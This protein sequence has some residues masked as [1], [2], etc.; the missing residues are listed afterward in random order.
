VGGHVLLLE[1]LI[2]LFAGVLQVNQLAHGHLARSLFVQQAGNGLG[3]I[4]Q[5]AVCKT[6]LAVVRGKGLLSYLHPG[7]LVPSYSSDSV[8]KLLSLLQPVFGQLFRIGDLQVGKGVAILP[9]AQGFT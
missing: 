9:N 5:R 6:W 7:A 3:I 8:L 2:L 4:V 1:V